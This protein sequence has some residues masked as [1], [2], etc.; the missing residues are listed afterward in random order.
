MRSTR[1]VSWVWI[2][3]AASL[4]AC[5]PNL[6]EVTDEGPQGASPGTGGPT[7]QTAGG[8]AGG[9]NPGTTTPATTT[10]SS[11]GGFGQ[12]FEQDMT[13]A[14]PAGSGTPTDP[15]T[16]TPVDP[17][18]PNAPV[19]PGD[20]ANP[21][22]TPGDP[23]SPTP[24]VPADVVPMSC[25]D[26][27]FADPTAPGVTFPYDTIEAQVTST[28]NNLS[29]AQKAEMMGGPLC[30]TDY[31]ACGYSRNEQFSTPEI[32]GIRGF[33]FRDGPR[34]ISE[35]EEENNPSRKATAFPVSVAR[36][37]TFD[38]NLEYR[39]GAAICSEVLGA[40]W[41]NTLAPT[42][43][44][45]KHPAA[46]RAQESYG[47]DPWWSGKMGVAFIVGCQQYA[48]ACAKH[49]VGN[50]VETGRV[51][52]SADFTGDIG[53][54]TLRENYARP[55]EMAVK[56][57][58]VSCIMASY[59]SVNGVHVTENQ[60]LLRG[61]L[62]D[63]WGFRGTVISDW[64]AATS[65]VPSAEAGLEVEMPERHHYNGIDA[66]VDTTILNTAVRNILTQKYRFGWADANSGYE[67]TPQHTPGASTRFGDRSYLE[68][69]DH[70][71]LAR[72]AATKAAVLLKNENDVLPLTADKYTHIHVIAAPLPSEDSKGMASFWDP[73]EEEANSWGAAARLGDKGSSQVFPSYRVSPFQG[74]MEG[75]P[76]GLNVTTENVDA[77]GVAASGAAAADV[78]VIVIVAALTSFDEGEEW[79]NGGD[80]ESL[81]LQDGQAELIAAATA[82][83]KPVVVVLEGGAPI[84]MESW[85]AGASSILMAWYPGMEGGHAIADLLYGK[86]N[87]SG[88][89]P[90]SWPIAMADA[91]PS[92]SNL[93]RFEFEYLHGYRMYEA[94]G[95]EVLFPFGYGLSYTTF[96]YSNV[97]VS[98]SDATKNSVVNVSLT[99]TNTGAVAGT[100][101]VQVYVG[102]PGGVSP[103][104]LKE[105]KTAARVENI[106]PGMSVPI[107]IPL[108]V[109]DWA[110]FDPALNDWAVE[111]GAHTIYVGSSSQN[112]AFEATV[113]VQ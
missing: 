12:T 73:W 44:L 80:R 112:I 57:A 35:W 104:P 24:V 71:Q 10:P 109:K 18:D 38:L 26:E 7:T 55:F 36:A 97:A 88:R 100:E 1:H 42:I 54:R 11:G 113:P 2:L 110:Y 99:V 31:W 81:E 91:G 94:N 13:G 25:G 16:P 90:Q 59:N 58:D 39:I 79:Q 22:V 106:P 82:L 17:S 72:E 37:A 83:G 101:V 6:E 45:T 63:D 41:N 46:G 23:A 29:N 67:D 40:G 95:T 103:R 75:A 92:G 62:R 65:G 5:V 102:F 86:A 76:A 49:F 8:A 89:L 87:F 84:T 105:F 111:S 19:T 21:A 52:T 9:T 61:L 60:A 64:A 34:G 53:T 93:A 69:P 66:Q 98:C 77:N 108:P 48:Q 85:R 20:P 56:D 96:E 47:E 107:S 51:S 14:T 15:N 70:L 28:L 74:M 4:S 68:H 30:A 33:R 32:A 50:E 43:N 78:D 27:N 3:A